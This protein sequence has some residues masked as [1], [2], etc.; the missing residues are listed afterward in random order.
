MRLNS[1]KILK[2]SITTDSR[3][4]ILEEIRKYLKE[5]SKSKAQRPKFKTKPLIVVTPN[6]EQ[7][8]LAQKNKYFA[9]L[10]N[11][12]DIA[13]PDGI[14]IVLAARILGDKQQATNGKW[15][16][17]RIPGVEFMENLVKMSVEER[18]PIALI[19][20]RQ[21]LAVRTL[22]CL[23]KKYSGL[24]GWAEDG[25]ELVVKGSVLGIKYNG[26]N[27]KSKIHNTKTLILNPDD[28]DNYFKR[29]A[30]RIIDSGVRIVFVG[31]GAP[32]QEFFIQ[33]L[34][35]EL[36]IHNY[37]LPIILM[38]V[39]GAFDEISGRLPAPPAF[40]SRWG[41]KW[42]WRLVL[43]PW[44]WRRQLALLE[45]ALLVIKERMRTGDVKR[46]KSQSP[47]PGLSV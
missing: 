9:D 3:Q 36:V 38:A 2:I 7:I 5:N 34:F 30:R 21:N 44:R 27:Q 15:K 29:V 24:A 13:L 19:G 42:L 28:Q 17:R 32:K 26:K 23:Q 39:G 33:A 1:V 43:E 8:V 10:L 35:R 6:P 20:G 40:V 18:V 25:P 4:K 31:L 11:R 22:D 14:G 45:F 16:P 46:S 37:E 12:A 41:F 47:D